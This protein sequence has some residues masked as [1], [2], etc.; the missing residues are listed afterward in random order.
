MKEGTFCKIYGNTLRN[1]VLE[2]ILELGE[3][4]FAVSDI[5]EE[6]NISKPKLYQIIKELEYDNIIL[7]SKKIGGTQLYIL[8]SKNI[9]TK[10]LI[11]AFNECIN[12]VI[13]ESKEKPL[14]AEV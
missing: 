2:F 3:L 13:E 7:T 10:L 6:L 14:I 11:K 1:R 5:L 4:D 12:I 8:N 9:K